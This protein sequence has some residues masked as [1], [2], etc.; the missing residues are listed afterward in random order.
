M[1]DEIDRD[2]DALHCAAGRLRNLSSA[3]ETKV[4]M[5]N[6][7]ISRIKDK[8][9]RVEERIVMYRSHSDRINC[10]SADSVKDLAN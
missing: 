3:M 10:L 8:T 1:E 2:L 7:H 5:Q 9:D 4:D 6:Q